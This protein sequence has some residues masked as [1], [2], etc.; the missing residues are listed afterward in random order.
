M[1]TQE[2]LNKLQPNINNFE[3]QRK[4]ARFTLLGM[5]SEYQLYL[6]NNNKELVYSKL[7]PKQHFLFKRVLH[8]LKMYKSEEI[9]DMHWDKK[10]RIT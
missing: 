1:F 7:N 6:Q 10:R 3:E 8:G 2:Q 9:K 4:I 5:L